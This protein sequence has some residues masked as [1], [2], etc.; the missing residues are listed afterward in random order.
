M[1]IPLMKYI[2]FYLVF[3]M[4]LTGIAPR[5][6]AGFSPSYSIT[7][8][9][10]DRTADIQKIQKLLEIKIVRERL[11]KFGLKEGEIQKRLNQLSDEQIHN[12]ASNIDKLELGGDCC[13]GLGVIIALLVI[14]ILIVLLI[15]LT[16]HRVIIK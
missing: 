14:A 4:F 11:K 1:K 15:Q 10:F 13:N 3:V 16:G 2:T 12:I 5:V 6:D 7:F 9:Q 8:S